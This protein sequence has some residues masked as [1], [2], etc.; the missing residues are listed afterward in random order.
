MVPNE[1][2]ESLYRHIREYQ[3]ESL[4]DIDFS[5]HTR[6]A[7]VFPPDWTDLARLHSLVLQRR[8]TTILEFGVGFSTLI[9]AHALS[10]NHQLYGDIPASKFRRGNAY[11]VHSVDTSDAYI[12]QAAQ[13]IPDSLSNFVFFHRS[14]ATMSTWGGKI[15]SLYNT[16]PQ[17]FPDFVYLDGPDPMD[18]KGTIRNVTTAH[19]D[20]LPMSADLL[21]I[22]YFLLPGTLILIDGRTANARFLKNNFQ[23]KWAHQ[24]DIEGD[25]HYLECTDPPL[26]SLNKRFLEWTTQSSS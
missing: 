7:A 11:Q 21:E 5:T 13:R 17:I 9:F 1:T 26:G 18:V 24:H 14:D 23:N 20:G 19:V 22:E 16:L 8:V 15:C 12:A 10:I 6:E 2:E 25:V 3:L 4:I